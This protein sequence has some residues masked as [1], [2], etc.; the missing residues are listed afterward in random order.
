M[1][2]CLINFILGNVSNCIDIYLGIFGNETETKTET[3]TE[4][5]LPGEKFIVGILDRDAFR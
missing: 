2:F 5:L 3:D 1:C 4:T